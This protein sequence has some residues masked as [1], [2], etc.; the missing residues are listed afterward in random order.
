M[1][2][3]VNLEWNKIFHLE[4][5]IVMYSI[6]NSETVEKLI[7]T[8]HNMHNK[9][10]CNENLFVGKLHKWYQWYL[11]EGA[12]YYAIN[13]ILYITILREKYIKMYEKFINQLKM[14]ANAVRVVSKGYLPISLLPQW[15]I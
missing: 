7:N 6:N 1:E 9:T 11:S 13:S 5:S 15:N 3:K 14:F 2:S 8:I 12:V 4:D 10:T